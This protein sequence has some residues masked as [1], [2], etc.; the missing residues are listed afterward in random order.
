MVLYFIMKDGEAYVLYTNMYSARFD[1]LFP[2]L[3]NGGWGRVSITIRQSTGSDC[4]YNDDH[5]CIHA[6]YLL[7]YRTSLDAFGGD[8]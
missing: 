2:I 1:I 4:L 3:Y 6:V 7:F 8:I 5:T